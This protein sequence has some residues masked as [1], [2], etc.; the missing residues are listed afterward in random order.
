[1]SYVQPKRKS[2]QTRVALPDGRHRVVTCGTPDEQT[3]EAMDA[4]L[5]TLARRRQWGAATAI[6]ERRTTLPE[7]FDAYEAGTLP[8]LLARIGEADLDALL[9]EWAKAGANARYVVQV[10]RLIPKGER[11]PV[12]EFRRKRL[13]AFLSSL[14]V[15]GPT[16]NRYKAALSMFARWLVEREVLETNPVRDIRGQPTPKRPPVFLEPAEVKALVMAL[17][18]P[19]RVL[20]ALMAGTGME[21]GA[22][23]RVARRDVNL[24]ARTIYARGTKNQYRT[25]YVEVSEP[26]AWEIIVEACREL[27]PLALIAPIRENAALLQHH[28]ASKALK[29][30]RT[31]LHTHRHS[32]AVMHIRRGS[33][34]QWIKNQLGHAPHSTLLYTTYGVYLAER[35]LI[36]GSDSTRQTTRLRV[37]G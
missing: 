37:K 21:W 36:S 3:A 13:S 23:S 29:L 28:A 8:A 20:G 25:R 1:M 10:R 26:W 9:T 4:M 17:H 35:T 34:H 11:F 27:S 22:A 32:F 7:V 15:K 6:I 16:K 19:A 33:D 24:E 5:R 14:P 12:S 30:R 31:V 18:G 2:R